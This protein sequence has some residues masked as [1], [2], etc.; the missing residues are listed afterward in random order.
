MSQPDYAMPPHDLDAEAA[1]LSSVL[2]DPTA[3]AEAASTLDGQD[4]YS[5]GHRRIWEACGDLSQSGKP[6]DVVT[7]M[8]RLRDTGRLQQVGGQAY[9]TEVLNA[10]PAVTHVGAYAAGVLAKAR[11]REVLREC[12]RIAAE[13]YAGPP[14]AEEWVSSAA[15]ALAR[16]ASKQSGSSSPEPIPVVLNRVVRAYQSV[17]AG[18]ITGISTGLRLLDRETGGLQDGE[19]TI[20]AGV[21]GVAKTSL[22]AKIGLSAAQLS[23]PTAMFSLEM[24]SEQVIGRAMCS[25]AQV[26]IKRART[27][28]LTPTDWQ[29]LTTASIALAEL[30]DNFQIYDKACSLAQIRAHCLR[31]DA[32]LKRQG[33]RLRLVIVDYVQLMTGP[34]HKAREELVS[35]NARGM[36]M[37]AKELCIAVVELSQLNRSIATRVNKRPM[38]SDLRESG[39]LEAAADSVLGLYRD[40]IYNRDS[41]RKG[42]VE[43][44]FMKARHGALGT[45]DVG[46]HGP[47]VT[48]RDLNDDDDNSE[49]SPWSQ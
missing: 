45:L 34:S 44:I 22:A 35:D 27:G 37:L 38:L 39:E 21:P 17:R 5:E 41:P 14:D 10:A 29:H 23:Y 43:I 31:M 26:E 7:V 4:F 12:Q 25:L 42:V 32:A 24:P 36:K 11:I 46:F 9:L 19:V 16:I 18:G 3:Y 20:I 33:K 30:G 48:F 28:M 1:V 47:T 2:I 8:T 13:A 15:M 6:I 40:E 49:P